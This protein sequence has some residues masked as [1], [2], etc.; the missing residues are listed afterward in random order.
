MNVIALFVLGLLVGWLAEW[1]I[2]WYYWR[3]RIY[4]LASENAGLKERAAAAEAAPAQ[5]FTPNKG[6]PLTDKS[7]RDNLEAINGIGPVFAKRLRQAGINSFA[8]LSELTPERLG[9]ILGERYRR[10][11]S[12]QENI[13]AQAKDFAQQ[14]AQE[15]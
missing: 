13:L 5:S 15:S 9:D 10:L 2:D 6:I 11:F 1:V 8:Q 7:G 14:K 4:K 3:T 12:N